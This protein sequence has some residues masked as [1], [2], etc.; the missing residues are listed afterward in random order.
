[1][2][3]MP[4]PLR[5]SS[6]WVALATAVLAT[7]S[8][9]ACKHGAGEPCDSSSSCKEG[10]SCI[11]WDEVLDEALGSCEAERCCTSERKVDKVRREEECVTLIAIVDASHQKA[12]FTLKTPIE[13][14][15]LAVVMD[16]HV[17]NFRAVELSDPTLAGFRSDYAEM[18]EQMAKAARTRAKH[19]NLFDGPRVFAETRRMKAI[20]AREAKLVEKITAECKPNEPLKPAFGGAP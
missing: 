19:I 20:A 12:T 6:W 2:I 17:A 13:L 10:L 1:M 15:Q 18:A 16:A 9:G 11:A 14:E 3:A 4:S 8:L 7:T 5:R